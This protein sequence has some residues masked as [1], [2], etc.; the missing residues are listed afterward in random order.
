MFKSS[1]RLEKHEMCTDLAQRLAKRGYSMQEAQSILLETIGYFESIPIGMHT[2][3]LNSAQIRIL[4]GFTPVLHTVRI[5][6]EYDETLVKTFVTTLQSML[7]M[8]KAH[9][10]TL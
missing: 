8:A 9:L 4:L 2:D 6:T 3:A 7:D 1:K 5:Q 10:E